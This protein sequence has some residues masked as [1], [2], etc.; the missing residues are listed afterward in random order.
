MPLHVDIKINEK[1]IDQLHIGRMEALYSAVQISTYRV[2]QGIYD[3]W[4]VP[5]ET[6]V[7]FQHQYDQG[8]LV[9]VE[10]AIEALRGK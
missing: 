5:F 8:A 7:E 3:S 1:L 6:G 10:K 2:V 9:C 4:A